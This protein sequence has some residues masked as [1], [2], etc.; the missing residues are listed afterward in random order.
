MSPTAVRVGGMLDAALE[1]ARHDDPVFAVWPA[2][3]D[4]CGCRVLD[5]KSPAKHPI[6]SR[7]R[8]VRSRLTMG[9]A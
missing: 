4:R 9:I 7:A 8:M 6:A 5:S 1:Y 3:G 2:E